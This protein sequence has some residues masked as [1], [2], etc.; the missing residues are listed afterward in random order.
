VEYR[1][2][3][4]LEVVANGTAANLGPPKQRAVLAVLLVHANEIVPTDR[5]IDLVW[6]AP[7]PPSPAQG[8]VVLHTCG[9][10]VVSRA[11][12]PMSRRMS[13]LCCLRMG[14]SLWRS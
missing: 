9:G 1:I 10:V 6:D 2:L 12:S 4:S 11:A 5:L 3:G 7:K 14:G 13:R 8:P